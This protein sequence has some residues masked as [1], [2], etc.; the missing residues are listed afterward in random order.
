MERLLLCLH[1]HTAYKIQKL[2]SSNFFRIPTW[3]RAWRRSLIGGRVRKS[4]HNPRAITKRLGM[5]GSADRGYSPGT[6]API[7]AFSRFSSTPQLPFQRIP[8]PLPGTSFTSAGA[9]VR[10]GSRQLSTLPARAET[11]KISASESS[12]SA[13]LNPGRRAVSVRKAAGTPPKNPRP[14][15]GEKIKRPSP[16]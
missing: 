12:E 11:V 2:H 10:N 7:F 15:G 4:V 3:K 9:T 16:A 6:S 5:P 1:G 13:I 8:I 14:G